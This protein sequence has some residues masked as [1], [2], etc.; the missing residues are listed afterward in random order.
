MGV[1]EEEISLMEDIDRVY[2]ENPFYGVR[3]I[4]QELRRHGLLCNHKRIWRLMQIMGLQALSPKKNLSR[5]N[6]DNL[7]YPYLL[8]GF[9]I[10]SSK[11][12]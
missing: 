7:I 8:K 4:T 9:K 5:R 12:V 3:K 11:G 2:T 10:T 1:T 6:R